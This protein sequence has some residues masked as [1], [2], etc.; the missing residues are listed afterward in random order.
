MRASVMVGVV[1]ALCVRDAAGDS[2]RECT[3][4]E[5]AAA[6]KE[7]GKLAPKAARARL[8]AVEKVCYP[9]AGTDDKPNLDAYWFW[10]DLAF[11]TFKDGDPVGCMRVLAGPTDPHDSTNRAIDGS[12]VGGALSYNWDLCSK[13]HD[14]AMSDFKPD[15]TLSIEGGAGYDEFKKAL[16]QDKVDDAAKLCPK[17]VVKTKGKTT[18]L[19][20]TEGLLV[21]T[22][23]CC[24]YNKVATAHRGGKRLVRL[25]SEYPSRDCFGGT[26]TTLLDTVYEWTG[27]ELKLV[28]DDSVGIH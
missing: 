28:E 18:T 3:H 13:A 19:H 27:N 10:S 9:S 14:K 20:A 12:K 21:S 5:L 24:G 22:S 2:S 6:R 26:A 15:A 17:L 23:N 1:M 7:A 25:S 8:E 16:D 11:A 4:A